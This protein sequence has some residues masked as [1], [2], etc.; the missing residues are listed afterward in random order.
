[1]S[2][3]VDLATI[4]SRVGGSSYVARLYHQ[5]LK[6]HLFAEA[7][8]HLWERP[9]WRIVRRVERYFTRR[10]ERACTGCAVGFDPEGQA[11]QVCGYIPIGPRQDLRCYDLKA[12]NASE[13][14]EVQL[15][16]KEYALIAR[17]QGYRVEE[18]RSLRRG[19]KDAIA[20]RKRFLAKRLRREPPVDEGTS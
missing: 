18:I 14:A 10:H 6:D 19:K 12:K 7:Y 9:T 16:E 8:H 11:V 5:P 15:S 20:V 4:T 1:M 13:I 17:A 3:Y 2:V